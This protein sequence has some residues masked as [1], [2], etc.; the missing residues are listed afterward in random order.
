MKLTLL[1]ALVVIAAT[2]A[3]IVALEL[4]ASSPA[5]PAARPPTALPAGVPAPQGDQASAQVAA[6]LARPPFT[7]NRRPDAVQGADDPRL[8]HLTG[9]LVTSQDRRAIFAGRNGG[10]GTVVAQ[11]DQVGAY[12][13]QDISATDVTLA[14]ADGA[15]VVRPSFSAAAPAPPAALSLPQFAPPPGATLGFPAGLPQN[16]PAPVVPGAGIAR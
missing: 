11:G 3:G 4:A 10:R 2:L 1:P 8:P 6:L 14:G 5:T 13:V 12:R 15:H 7:P 9:I 16:T